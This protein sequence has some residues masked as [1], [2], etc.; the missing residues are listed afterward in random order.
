MSYPRSHSQELAELA[1]KPISAQLQ[2]PPDSAAHTV[3]LI[4]LLPICA[5]KTLRRVTSQL[6]INLEL[7]VTSVSRAQAQGI[8]ARDGHI[9]T[10]ARVCRVL[11]PQLVLMA[12]SF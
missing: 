1:F 10:Q 5:P 4:Y 2:A 12:V 11:T 3:Y 9:S 6:H 8:G 7:L